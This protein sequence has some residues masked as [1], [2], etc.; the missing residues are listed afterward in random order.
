MK[1]KEFRAAHT[2]RFA[3]FAAKTRAERAVLTAHYMACG[4]CRR[5]INRSKVEDAA[6][7]DP[8]GLA[9]SDVADP[10]VNETMTDAFRKEVK[11]R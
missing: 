10:E 9:A 11:R 4:P 6:T 5:F 2:K 1:C 3:D 7:S 8:H